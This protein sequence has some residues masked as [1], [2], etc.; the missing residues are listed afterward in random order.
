LVAFFFAAF[1]FAILTLREI[2]K[3]IVDKRVRNHQ[4]R[5]CDSRLWYRICLS[6]KK[7]VN[8]LTKNN[9]LM[10]GMNIDTKIIE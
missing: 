3:V 9:L 7:I 4:S 5:R 6:N 2:K 8:V 1:L 10:K